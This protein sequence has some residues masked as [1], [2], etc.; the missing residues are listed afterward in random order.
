MMKKKISILL[1]VLLIFA[2]SACGGTPPKEK[3]S[4]SK[5]GDSA[6]KESS[7][8][9]ILPSSL[10]SLDDASKILAAEMK[11]IEL[12]KEMPGGA[13]HCVYDS[14][15]NLFQVF[16]RQDALMKGQNKEIGGAENY[17]KEMVK[18]QKE[19]SPKFITAVENLGEEAYFMDLA[20]TN[21]WSLHIL[22][23]GYLVELFLDGDGAKDWKLDL[24]NKAG[25]L[26]IKNLLPQI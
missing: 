11:I 21:R 1:I 14:G 10:I 7:A 25:E 6:N 23:S 16:I 13:L 4:A 15:S 9:L 22:E 18:Y 20:E 26:A 19:S 17:F 12:D 3:D 2:L 5:P 8:D 24:L